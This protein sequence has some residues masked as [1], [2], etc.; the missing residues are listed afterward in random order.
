M[1]IYIFIRSI[2][3]RICTSTIHHDRIKLTLLIWLELL[4]SRMNLLITIVL[5]LTQVLRVII[6]RVINT[7][8][9]SVMENGSMYPILLLAF[10]IK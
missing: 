6:D 8:K 3:N 5:H 7:M 10:V 4:Q 9:E 2:L 1:Y